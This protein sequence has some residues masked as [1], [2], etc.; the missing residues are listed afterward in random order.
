M[1]AKCGKFKSSN[2]K[3]VRAHEVKCS[4]CARKYAGLTP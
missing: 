2:A 4:T 3:A 1:R